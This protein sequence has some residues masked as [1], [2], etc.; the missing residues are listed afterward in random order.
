MRAVSMA[1][2]AYTSNSGSFARCSS[3]AHVARCLPRLV[4][5]ER[6]SD[7]LSPAGERSGVAPVPPAVAE[8]V[9]PALVRAAAVAPASC[10]GEVHHP[11]A[12]TLCGHHRP[13]L[14][15]QQVGT[16]SMS[17]PLALVVSV[18]LKNPHAGGPPNLAKP[19]CALKS[20][21]ALCAFHSCGF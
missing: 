20:R 12:G 2:S 18:L 17:P 10:P 1:A 7:G 3:I 19:L 5:A 8:P 14:G 6:V 9:G 16:L 11:D 15:L 4:V 13:Q 21:H